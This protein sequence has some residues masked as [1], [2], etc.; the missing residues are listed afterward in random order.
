VSEHDWYARFGWFVTGNWKFI[1]DG[2][3]AIIAAATAVLLYRRTRATE[4]LARAALEQART[5]SQQADTA[6]KRHEQQ[7]DADRQRRITESFARAIEQLGSEKLEARVG[8]VHALARIAQESPEDHWPI[9]ETLTAFVREK[10][11]LPYPDI[12]AVEKLKRDEQTS[13]RRLRSDVQAALTAIGH[14]CRNHDPDGKRLDLG[15]TNL[16]R[17]NLE[18][19]Y[20]EKANLSGALLVEA[21]LAEAHLDDA[22]LSGAHLEG[23][24]LQFAQLARVSLEGAHLDGANLRGAVFDVANLAGATLTNTCLVDADLRHVIVTQEQLIEAYGDPETTK[25]PEGM[26]IQSYRAHSGK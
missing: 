3:L 17:A 5:A 15:G 12:E 2:F 7:T 24:I 6:S 13:P 26:T 25:L 1:R 4:A 18:A 22:Y 14:R 19:A 8:G 9:M 20:L 11:A 16:S 23:A 10:T 21:L